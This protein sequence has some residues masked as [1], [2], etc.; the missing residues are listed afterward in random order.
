M[1]P[2]VDPDQHH[3][4]R[5]KGFVYAEHKG[6]R[7]TE[8]P[9]GSEGAGSWFQ[10]QPQCGTIWETRQH[11]VFARGGVVKTTGDLGELWVGSHT[12]PR[13]VFGDDPPQGWDPAP[14]LRIARIGG[15]AILAV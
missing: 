15:A 6:R 9:T 11:R 2:G 14:Q 1:S 3:L 10:F 4:P 8:S 12:Q 7:S 13:P 5:E